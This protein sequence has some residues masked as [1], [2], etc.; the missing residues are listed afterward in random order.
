MMGKYILWGKD[1]DTGKNA[2][3]MGIQLETKHGTWDDDRI[4]SLDSLLE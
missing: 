1:P 2:K 3:Q 4:E